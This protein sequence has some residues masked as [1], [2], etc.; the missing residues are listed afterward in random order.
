MS[1]IGCLS[2]HN[3]IR[4]LRGLCQR[5]YER[6]RE[7]IAEGAVTWADLVAQGLAL[8]A[9]KPT[10]GGLSERMRAERARDTREGRL[11]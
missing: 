8:P 2:C 9:Q 4:K 1:V 11:P 7:A 5:C 3:R 10:L 6:A